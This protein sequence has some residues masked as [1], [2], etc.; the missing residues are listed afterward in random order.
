[1]FKYKFKIVKLKYLVFPFILLLF[2]FCLIIFS[3]TNLIAAKKGL[4]LWANS[5]IPALF[6]FFVATDLLSHTNFVYY[7][8]KIF[9]KYMYPIF[10]VRGEGIFALIMG[11][12]SGYPVGAK[13]ATEFRK[14]NICSKEECE[15]LISFTNNSGP[16]FIIGTVGISMFENST[17]GILLLISHILASIT[18][19]VIFRFWKCK[20]S[21]SKS[22]SYHNMQPSDNITFSNLGGIIGSSITSSIN[23]ILM[24][25]GFIVLF[26]VILS[27]LNSSNILT[28]LCTTLN[29]IF[30]SLHIPISFTKGVISGIIELTNGL[31]IICSIPE[32]MISINIMLASFILGFGG[33]S[34]LLQVWS[35]ISKSDLSIKPYI[36]GKILQAFIS[37]FY[38]C[39]L[40]NSFIIFNFNL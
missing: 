39:L 3:N 22:S 25:G 36:Y 24:I 2:I 19:G 40:I 29:P 34:V 26:S 18:V 17:I 6:P 12:I 33:F 30:E 10:N 38:T 5:V 7:L 35:I 4:Q 31:N 13:I 20:K 11:L 9:N 14:N 28:F 21:L 32:K 37:V 23:T 1:M 27:I 15:R 16:L 8:G